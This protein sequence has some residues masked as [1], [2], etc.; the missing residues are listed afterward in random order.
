MREKKIEISI[1]A[2]ISP[3]IILIILLA[4]NVGIYGDD[5]LNGSNQFILLVGAFIAAIV[6]Y[7]HKV[8]YKKIIN[9]ISK[10]VKAT[11]SP[12]L[13]LLF[14]G[15]L[16][17]T[18]LISGIIP[19][20]IYY[21]LQIFHPL[22]FLPACVIICAIISIST[23]SSWTT[24][25]TIGI[26]LV[27]IGKAMEINTGIVAGAII[28]GAYFGDKLSPLSD[29][30]NLASAMAN[31][32]LFN[33]IRYMTLT[34]VPSIIIS[35]LFFISIGFFQ[36]ST[37]NINNR[38]L[39]SSIEEKFFINPILFIVPILVIFMI[40]KKTP[41]LIA[42]MMGTILAALFALIFQ[43]NIIL[44]LTNTNKLTLN[45]AYRGIIDAITI[46][47][48]IKSSNEIL[49][50]LFKSGGMK[51]ML[52]T[53]WLIICAMVFGG[54]RMLLEHSKRLANNFLKKPKTH[55]S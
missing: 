33:H 7:F 13:I 23:G 24:S 30:T 25:A 3:I 53:I 50:E 44:E 16:A 17:G 45:T 1:I 19:A 47:T 18:W 22:F 14:V 52:D 12:I 41:P 4:V 38:F 31:S 2:S 35:L 36:V 37:D 43:Q 51:G 32:N 55:F 11:T 28:S 40:L 20:M 48:T 5:S 34:T 26:A 15:A 54:V 29:T 27:G 10:S 49:A 6:G 42:L 21:G 9:S 39:F 8:S 46:E